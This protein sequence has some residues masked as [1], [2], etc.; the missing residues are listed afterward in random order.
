MENP[1]LQQAHLDNIGWYCR[2]V[3]YPGCWLDLKV[4]DMFYGPSANELEDSKWDL[5]IKMYAKH[6][7]SYYHTNNAHRKPLFVILPGPALFCV[8]GQTWNG[9]VHEGGWTVTGVEPNITVHPSINLG[10]VYHG[11]LQNGAITK[12]CE[13]RQ[14]TE[15]GYLIRPQQG[16][17]NVST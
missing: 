7:S 17:S 12:E 3:E 8:D 10:G 5:I 1:E 6:L 13:G 2:M 4:G 16:V 15:E 11:F 14:Y 9:G